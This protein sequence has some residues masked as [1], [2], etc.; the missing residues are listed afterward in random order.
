MLTYLKLYSALAVQHVA[1]Q[2]NITTSSLQYMRY[3]N[4]STK[5][6]ARI[7]RCRVSNL[8]HI[9]VPTALVTA[10]SNNRMKVLF[11]TYTRTHAHF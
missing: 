3:Y 2:D 9:P 5:F 1:F 11:K 10:A 8:K 6:C 7:A 4:S